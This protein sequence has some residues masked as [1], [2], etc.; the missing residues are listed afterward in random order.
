MVQCL[1]QKKR[2][3]QHKTKQKENERKGRKEEEIKATDAETSFLLVALED[4]KGNGKG[5]KSGI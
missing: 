4:E 1:R 2:K 5:G 3:Q